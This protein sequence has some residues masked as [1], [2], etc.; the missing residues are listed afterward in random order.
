MKN[1]LLHT[2]SDLFLLI[3]FLLFWLFI[4]PELIYHFQQLGFSS[5]KSFLSEFLSYPGGIAEYISLFLFQFNFKPLVGAL[6]FTIVLSLIIVISGGVFKFAGKGLSVFM[7][8]APVILIAILLT[9]YSFHPVYIVQLLF[10]LTFFLLLRITFDSNTRLAVKLSLTTF[11]LLAA[12]YVI[13]GLPF[14]I[15][16]VS[17]LIHLLLIKKDFNVPKIILITSLMLIVPIITS[18]FFSYINPSDAF[19]KFVPYFANYKPDI[20]TYSIFL[21]LPFV[22]TFRGFLSL[23]CK[24]K[25]ESKE[26]DKSGA[27]FYVQYLLSV[28]L[29]VCGILLS[30]SSE[31]KN[32]ITVDYL[33]HNQQWE[34]LLEKVKANPSEDRLIQFHT[35]RALYFTGV[36]PEKMFEYSQIWGLDGLFVNRFFANEVLLPSTELYF[37]LGLINEA[38]QYGNE[39][40]SQNENSPL[41]IEQLVIANITSDKYKSALIY[42]NQL[43][44]FR[45]FK[46]KALEYE[47][48]LN[49]EGV[50]W[51]DSLVIPKREVMPVNDFRVKRQEP[52][53]DLIN[54]LADNLNNKMAYEYLMAAFLLENDLASFIKYYSIGKKFNY[55]NIPS[56]YQQAL[57]SYNYELM[58]LDKPLRQ[59][60]VSKEI[61]EKFG[62]Y[63]SVFSEFEGDRDVAQAKLKEKF[64]DTYWYYLHF[65]SPVTNKK[66]IV[67]E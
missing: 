56:I 35:N 58:R 26:E 62:E 21:L 2:L 17:I 34:E 50:P 1:K 4:K 30:L 7:R 19:F 43:K 10:F 11:L 28:V 32:K 16:S 3:F 42:I 48:Y 37:E 65:L 52:Q 61:L 40:V 9:D 29:L 47:K 63:M 55:K 14:M 8:F 31:Q 51:I 24:S 41:V 27:S 44:N 67:V 5:D 59:I 46:K 64:G 20:I 53:S 66:Q 15:L 6:V 22:L 33:A 12:Y 25:L 23:L 49:G 36:M 18:N 13:G 54:M 39:S 45:F 60:T 57:I 38:I